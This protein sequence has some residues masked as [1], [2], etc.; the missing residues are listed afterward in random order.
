MEETMVKGT[1]QLQNVKRLP[2]SAHTHTRTLWILDS[3]CKN[4]RH[5][6]VEIGN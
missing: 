6:K 3:L 2:I 1:K 4:M 5:L